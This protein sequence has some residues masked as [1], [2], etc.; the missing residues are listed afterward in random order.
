[1][2]CTVKGLQGDED[3]CSSWRRIVWQSTNLAETYA[4]TLQK[5]LAITLG[6]CVQKLKR[7]TRPNN[8]VLKKIV[9]FYFLQNSG[10]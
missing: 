10:V 1:M 8:V 9:C 7:R 4:V 6:L 2:A 5:N 3:Y